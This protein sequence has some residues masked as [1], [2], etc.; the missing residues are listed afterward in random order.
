MCR[1]GLGE[2]GAATLLPSERQSS[3][4][5]YIARGRAI[6]RLGQVDVESPCCFA[7]LEPDTR[8]VRR[9]IKARAKLK[10][11]AA[12]VTVT[13][14]CVVNPRH[15][16]S[17]VIVTRKDVEPGRSRV[18]VPVRL[19]PGRRSTHGNAPNRGLRDECADGHFDAVYRWQKSSDVESERTAISELCSSK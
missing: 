7:A 5:G 6:G 1:L 4:R 10:D 15:V 11:D 16:R 14:E 8:A 2:G 17:S 19:E 12:V 13:P 9:R 18:L 3:H